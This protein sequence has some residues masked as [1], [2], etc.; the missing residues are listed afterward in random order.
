VVAELRSSSLRV[1]IADDHPFYR[2]GLARL[3]R[4][5]GIDVVGE[6]SS[7][8]PAIRAVE[9]TAPDVVVMNLKMPGVSGL[10][11]TRR[12]S[13]FAAPSPVLMLSVSAEEEDVTDAILAG[14]S[15]YVLKDEPVEVLVQAIHMV[16]AG[17]PLI[18]PRVATVLLQRVLDAIEAGSDLAGGGL[19]GRELEVLGLLAGGRSD[20]EIAE[21]LSI[22]RTTVGEHVASILTKLQVEKRV[23]AVVKA[24]HSRH[25]RG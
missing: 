5:S 2:G 9:D 8:E 14:A 13:E 1:V 22:S 7:G 10:E 19:S 3:L 25:R 11:A 20:V 4:E 15:G 17:K 16:A 12:L 23:Q 18:S 21:A 24:L 6:A